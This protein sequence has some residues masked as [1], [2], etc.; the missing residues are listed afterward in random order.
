MKIIPIIEEFLLQLRNYD[1]SF[2]ELHHEIQILNRREE[3]DQLREIEIPRENPTTGM[4]GIES[5]ISFKN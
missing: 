3:N 5:L 2:G 4:Y 1:K